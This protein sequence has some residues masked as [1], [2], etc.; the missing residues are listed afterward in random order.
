MDTTL[1]ETPSQEAARQQALKILSLPLAQLEREY[2]QEEDAGK[3]DL[4]RGALSRRALQEVQAA[5]SLQGAKELASYIAEK[6]NAGEYTSS[7]VDQV[8]KPIYRKK[9][10]TPVDITAG[11]VAKAAVEAIP[12]VAGDVVGGVKGMLQ[13]AYPALIGLVGGAME[14][15]GVG[16]VTP[17]QKQSLE[18]MGT[19]ME[20]GTRETL[21]LAQRG[22]RLIKRAGFQAPG[23]L[24]YSFANIESDEELD[25][26][27]DSD[28][29]RLRRLRMVEKGERDVGF[30]TS[31]LFDEKSWNQRRDDILQANT[32]LE[33]AGKPPMLVPPE[34]SELKRIEKENRPQLTEDQKSLISPTGELLDLTNYGPGFA[35]I[36][37]AAKIEKATAAKVIQTI[38]E[39]AAIKA[40]KQQAEVGMARTVAGKTV[41]KAGEVLEKVAKNPLARGAIAYS[42]SSE[43][44]TAVLT[45]MLGASNL[46]SRA[47]RIAPQIVKG[48]GKML[49]EPITGPTGRFLKFAKETGK[50]GAYGVAAMT[51]LAAIGETPQEIGT[52]LTGGLVYGAA[53]GG[54]QSS[55]NSVTSF[56]HSLWTPD[57][58]GAPAN[59]PRALVTQY[60][61]AFDAAHAAYVNQ[62]PTETANRIEALRQLV[63]G[64]S[65]L[66]VLD[67]ASYAQ[68]VPTVSQGVASVRGPDGVSRTFIRGGGEALYHE[69]GHV[70]FDSLTPEE[71]SSVAE[72]VKTAYS[73]EVAAQMR[74]Y[75]QSMGIPIDTPDALLRE[76]VAENF[77]VALNGGPLGRLGTPPSLAARI[78]STLGGLAERAGL[79]NM[80]PGGPVQTS[81]SLKFT[82]S[83]LVN[84][85]IRNVLEAHAL[86][87][88]E[89]QAT[90][91]APPAV[92]ATVAPE[93]TQAAKPAP[94]N[95][96]VTNPVPAELTVDPQSP[97]NPPGV[98]GETGLSS[99]AA[100]LLDSLDAGAGV[101]AFIT[102]KLEKI[103]L[104]NGLVVTR[105]T[106]PGEIIQQLR[107][108]RVRAGE[109]APAGATPAPAPAPKVVAP[110]VAG[111][112]EV[113]RQAVAGGLASPELQRENEAILSA[114]LKSPFT[115]EYQSADA[116]TTEPIDAETRRRQYALADAAEADGEINPLRKGFG[117][118]FSPLR[119]YTR[120]EG[121]TNFYNFS[122]DKLIRNMNI[123]RGWFLERGDTRAAAKIFSPEFQADVRAYLENQSN[124]YRG[125]GEKIIRPPDTN[126]ALFPPENPDY[127]PT[128]LSEQSRN[129]INVLMGLDP[130]SQTAKQAF[131]NNL[132]KL[133]GFGPAVT[134]L[135]PKGNKVYFNPAMKTLMDAGFNP[136]LLHS[137]IENLRVERMTSKVVPRPDLTI[138][139]PVQ[140]SV[141]AG[142]MPA[143]PVPEEIIYQ[144]EQNLPAAVEAGATT[145]EPRPLGE[146][147]K[148]GNL[149]QTGVDPY[150]IFFGEGAGIV[151]H[152]FMPSPEGF[153]MTVP[154]ES[155][156]DGAR[157]EGSGNLWVRQSDAPTN[158]DRVLVVQFEPNLMYP[159]GPD[160]VST[161]YYDKLYSGVREG[162][163]R[164]PDFWELPQ[165]QASVVSNLGERVDGYYVSDIEE[166]K[167][168]FKASNYGHVAFSVMDVSA[169]LT[170]QVASS[171][172]G[173]LHLGGYT[174]RSAIVAEH[175]NVKVYDNM[176]TFVEAFGVPY[177]NDFDYRL[178]RGT[179]TI[180]R[181][182]MSAGCRHRCT[183]CTIERKVIERPF[184]DVSKQAASFKDLNAKLVYLNDKTFGQAQVSK[185]LPEIYQQ[186]KAANPDFSGFIIQT[187]AAQMK[188]FSD[189][190]LQESGIRYVELG[191]ETFN[192]SILKTLRK[193][194]TE[195]LINE[196][197]DKLRR[198]GV[199]FIPN[200]VIGFP[201]ETAETYGRT[202]KF[203]EGNADVISHVNTYNLAIYE[204]TEM[205]Q[206]VEA[207]TA[208]DADENSP[209]KSFYKD[210]KV[211][212]EFAKWIYDYG[213]RML[214]TKQFMPEGPGERDAS[215]STG[216]GFP[217]AKERRMLEEQRKLLSGHLSRLSHSPE[218]REVA[219]KYMETTGK[220][221][222]P[223]QDY[224][225][226]D[227]ELAREVA[228]FYDAAEDSPESP[229]VREA[230]DALAKETMAQ[231]EAMK[232]AGVTIEPWPGK[233]EPYA[234]SAEMLKDVRDNRHLWFFTTDSGSGLGDADK[235]NALLQPSGVTVNGKPLVVNDIFRAVHDYFGHAK[236][237]FEFGPRGE[238]NA[239]L[240]HSRMFSREATRALAAETLAQNSWVNYGPQLRRPNGSLPVQG[241]PDFVPLK[242]RRFADQKNVAVPDEFIDRADRLASSGQ[243]MP[244]P[245]VDSE[246]FK[247]W[248]GDSKVVGKSG[249]P[250]L[251]YHGTGSD[252][253]AF[254]PSLGGKNFGRPE[255]GIFFTNF[256][257]D[258]EAYA[259]NAAGGRPNQYAGANLIPA[260]V[261]LH[262]PLVIEEDSM[263]RGAIGLIEDRK[264]LR[265]E[266][267]D[268]LSSNEYDG[269]V[270]VATDMEKWD[271]GD[272]ETMVI[273]K[274][275]EQI[276]SAIGN[277][278]TYDPTNPDI[279]HMP[280]AEETQRKG[281]HIVNIG[282]KVE[283]GDDLSPTEVLSALKKHGLNVLSWEVRDSAT[284][285]TVIATVLGGTPKAYEDTAATLKQQAI[286]VFD[287][288]NQKGFL[289]GPQKAAWEPFKNEYFLRPTI[290]KAE[291][292]ETVGEK[293]FAQE[294]PPDFMPA[295]PV[296][297]E[298]F[299][300]WFG[301]SKV[302]DADGK[303][304]V[305]YHGTTADFSSFDPRRK[306]EATR[307]DSAAYGFFFSRSPEIATDYATMLEGRSTREKR[308]AVEEAE[309][310]A[311]KTGNWANY[312]RLVEEYEGV[313]LAERSG[314]TSGA[315]ILPVF[316]SLKNPEVVD[317]SGKS[318]KDYE[319]ADALYTAFRNRRDGVILHNV[320]DS[321]KNEAVPGDVYVAFRPEQIKSATGNR[322]T[323][324]PTNP[325]IRFM[326]SPKDMQLKSSKKEGSMGE[327]LKLVHF[328]SVPLKVLNPRKSWGKGA[329]TPTDMRG[330]PRG[331]FYRIGEGVYEAGIADRPHIYTAV[332][333]GNSVYNL[334]ED[335][336]NYAGIANRAKA[337]QMLIDAGFSGMRGYN[338]A[339]DMVAMFEPVKLTPAKPEDV[340]SKE[341]LKAQKARK[342][343]K[344]SE[345]SP[346][347]P[348]APL[349]EIDYAK[350]DENW[351]FMPPSIEQASKMAE[352]VERSGQYAEEEFFKKVWPSFLKMTGDPLKASAKNFAVAAE[353]AVSDVTRFV[354]ENPKYLDYYHKDWKVTEQILKERFPQMTEDDFTAFRIFT[355]LT[356]PS[357]KLPDNLV[358]SVNLLN[359]WLKDGN[360]DAIKL[361]TNPETGNRKLGETPFTFRSTTGPGKAFATKA[362]AR[363]ILERGAEATASLL[364]EGVTVKELQEFNR[365]LGYKSNVSDIGPIRQVVKPATGQD[366]L[367]P[368]AFVFGQKVGAYTLNMLGED[369][370][371]TTDVWESRFIR[372][373]FKGMFRE[374]FGLPVNVNEQRIFQ[375]FSS[376]FAEEFNRRF[377]VKLSPAA[378]QAV[379]WFY[380]ID[381]AKRSGYRYAKTNESISHYT[382]RAIADLDRRDSGNRG[383]S[384]GEAAA[385]TAPV[386][387]EAPPAGAAPV[388]DLTPITDALKEQAKAI[389]DLAA[390][391]REMSK[392]P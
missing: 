353:Q 122:T 40:A 332:V 9:R 115:V 185:R 266:V 355:G 347:K 280:Q 116:P 135:G 294:M 255:P 184:A 252:F 154:R 123:L 286:A 94:V 264:G 153:E 32:E 329:A 76:I 124:G 67:P 103:A 277:R 241:D 59:T 53:G 74:N 145:G 310:H 348:L 196:A 207:K 384:D 211:H 209:T 39:E 5:E 8:M 105:Q 152:R 389:S 212:E 305:V 387:P 71:Q 328:S 216:D 141:Q 279:R 356:S 321:P 167:R 254:D 267:L 383:P 95:V 284:E 132:A 263:G 223:H 317:L 186:M 295:P 56:G 359:V 354:T 109:A 143:A 385:D 43:P 197:V 100:A 217:T 234:N 360:L 239:Y 233:G 292:I 155:Y 108:K 12:E 343:S 375:E 326:P 289:A 18:F 29:S 128:K 276:K 229:Q 380:F 158:A 176:A 1:V 2:S 144:V 3:K 195:K 142:F 136:K 342:P 322:G 37:A 44:G 77:Q 203:L 42:L 219:E 159:D 235:S 334:N 357:T 312:E 182:E 345:G 54:V 79:R 272:Y 228:D 80:A 183:F 270:A 226:V 174:D 262:N 199:H 164:S 218:I 193:P 65:E 285:P 374:N 166:A 169:E 215:V 273:A 368:R 11:D 106:T 386:V 307:S 391:Q 19:A 350:Q 340:Y 250:L 282:M 367:I 134:G 382:E 371:T 381:A 48:A 47:A 293:H 91:V 388:V 86:D 83:F 369:R 7:F 242:N 214:E 84:R 268:A 161:P 63:K 349:E 225:P 304:L 194:A 148:L 302:V 98:T 296:D 205:S 23:M 82:P 361:W 283:A 238:L 85:A 358:D 243:F 189:E 378:L 315:N 175:P 224:V 168:F 127:S 72:A 24:P 151:P 13:H 363:I 323:Y 157:Q 346:L 121:G 261:A 301:N 373:Y 25:K 288:D 36:K 35:G 370:Y 139:P 156:A 4:L 337:D 147:G 365:S 311:R 70:V 173:E 99:D 64:K 165:W 125:D 140:G 150:S 179:A 336:L 172:P 51:P 192:D 27:F 55:I 198:N 97:Y 206:S 111:V 339:T 246:A 202:K 231:Y 66:Y 14:S 260:Y 6:Q 221:Y 236:E 170:R 275:P 90:P 300:N 177:K 244:A 68:A 61:G 119:G 26:Q 299:K 129:L 265:E 101:P 319:F 314:I 22:A 114:N 341:N 269:V 247:K 208:A 278:G 52:L 133:N 78:Y 320:V 324:D 110:T 120:G 75:Y 188:L 245:P 107:D 291:Q 364:K 190:F 220:P 10:R 57:E 232:D 126:P 21:G 46:G 38:A 45:A 96:G 331:Y 58:K 335:P 313:E 366:E 259:K 316:L 274:R 73:P 160:P 330:L 112:T 251:V 204:G 191:V 130:V 30:L 309:K 392:R 49:R 20:Q 256:V 372:S 33:A 149:P 222:F 210:P 62:L 180:P 181:L 118:L 92:V 187:T 290:G 376:A 258:A 257:E 249:A 308:I 237:G 137:V 88:P 93:A 227:V 178:F 362:I 131:V 377:G 390:A 240:A 34:W 318:W 171:I 50:A 253:S 379:R 344:T 338:G 104:D 16:Y 281:V 248:F 162:Y 41:E 146:D 163:K 113:Q 138:K 351:Q 306:G 102:K 303:P 15:A 89:I 298:A 28:L 201:G 81:E 213:T 87:T 60:G 287:E 17:E 297:S 325:D 271:T 200:I 327:P 230:Y 117:K 333:D 31:L 69:V 352:D